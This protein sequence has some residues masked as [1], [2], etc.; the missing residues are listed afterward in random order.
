MSRD[1]DVSAVLILVPSF[2][3]KFSISQIRAKKKKKKKK[4]DFAKTTAFILYQSDV[5]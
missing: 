4:R 3:K 5:K 2:Y 1:D